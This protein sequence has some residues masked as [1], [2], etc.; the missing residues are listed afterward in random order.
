[1]SYKKFVFDFVVSY[2]E[3]FGSFI[4]RDNCLRRV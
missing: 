1:M 4:S 3:S 2:I